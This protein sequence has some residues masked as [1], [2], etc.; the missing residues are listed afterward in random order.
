MKMRTHILPAC[1]TNPHVHRL[2]AKFRHATVE[3]F[4][5]AIAEDADEQMEK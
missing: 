2:C 1:R 4:N 5:H 3:E